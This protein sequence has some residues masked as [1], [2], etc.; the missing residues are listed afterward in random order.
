MAT[1]TNGRLKIK[2]MIK[3]KIVV[4]DNYFIVQH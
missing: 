1:V 2:H 4:A 3:K